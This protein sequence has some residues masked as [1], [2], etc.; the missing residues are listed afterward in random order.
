[1]CSARVADAAPFAVSLRRRLHQTPE[2]GFEEVHTTGIL[3]SELCVLGLEPKCGI[4]VTGL[5]ARLSFSR[6]GPVVMIRADMDACP[7]G[8]KPDFP[9]PPPGRDTCTPAATM[10]TWL[11]S[12]EHACL[13]HFTLEIV[14]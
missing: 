14:A 10:A 1:M 7:C 12:W 9:L 2:D 13:R 5:T 4:A 8:R 11:W 3:A 6:P